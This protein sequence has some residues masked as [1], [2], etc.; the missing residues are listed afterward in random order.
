M[1]RNLSGSYAEYVAVPG[2]NVAAIN[3]NLAWEDLAAIPESYA[4]AWSA[5]VGNLALAR[6][7][8]C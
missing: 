2:S 6:D 8:R 5:L 4:T 1:G 7:T 3:T